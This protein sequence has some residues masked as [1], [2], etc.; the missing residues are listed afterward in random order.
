[1]LMNIKNQQY[2]ILYS[3]FNH[4][5]YIST[6]NNL[7]NDMHSLSF[8]TNFAENEVF[9]LGQMLKQY[10]KV[11]FFRAMDREMAGYNNRKH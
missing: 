11:E 8:A 9:Y 10:N 3:K 4:K 6:S 7:I 5:I 2:Y 1:M